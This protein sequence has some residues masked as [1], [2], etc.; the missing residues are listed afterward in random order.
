MIVCSVPPGYRRT[1]P[2]KRQKLDGFT[3]IIDQ[4]LL[5]DAGRPCKQRHTARRIADRLRDEHGFTG[6]VRGV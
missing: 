1:A 3:W 4:W 5:E 6:P 2:V